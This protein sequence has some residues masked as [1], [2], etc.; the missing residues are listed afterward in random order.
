MEQ[1]DYDYNWTVGPMY[2]ASHPIDSKLLIQILRS[3][4]TVLYER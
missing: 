1:A 2:H 3:M 4:A